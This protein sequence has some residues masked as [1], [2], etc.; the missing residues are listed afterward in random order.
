MCLW[1]GETKHEG[2]GRKAR[3]RSG[4]SKPLLNATLNYTEFLQAI[5]YSIDLPVGGNEESW[6]FFG[7]YKS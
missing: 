6:A 5:L 4:V 2:T 3:E 1:G 7:N